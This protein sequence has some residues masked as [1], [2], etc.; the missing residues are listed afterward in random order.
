MAYLSNR[1]IPT[2][3]DVL[4]SMHNYYLQ[5]GFQI[6][7]VKGDSEFNP[8]EDRMSELYGGPILNL[9]SAN[10]KVPV[11]EWKIHVIKERVCVVVYSLPVN[12]LP[13]IRHCLYAEEKNQSFRTFLTSDVFVCV[14]FW[15]GCLEAEKMPKEFGPKNI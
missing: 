12:S 11:I 1:K 8:L 2:I 9:A 15:A 5:H 7:F 13:A 3:F 4:R 14:Y 10:E 6:V